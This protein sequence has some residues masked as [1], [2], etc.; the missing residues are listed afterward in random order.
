MKKFALLIILALALSGCASTL[1]TQTHIETVAGKPITY[2]M[3]RTGNSMLD[4]SM[5]CDRYGQDG[6]MLAHDTVTNNGVVET[7]GGVIIQALSS[8]FT[9]VTAFLK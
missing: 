4:H 7:A 2:V 5:I 8:A 1:V 9:A 3:V 6:T